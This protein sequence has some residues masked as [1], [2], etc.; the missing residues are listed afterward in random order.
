MKRIKKIVAI[1]LA[2]FVMLMAVSCTQYNAKD[3]LKT[4]KRIRT[5]TNPTKKTKIHK[6]KTP[7]LSSLYGMT[8]D[9]T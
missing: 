3:P 6:K 7:R 4:V 5:A 8:K 2:V 9:K 1:L